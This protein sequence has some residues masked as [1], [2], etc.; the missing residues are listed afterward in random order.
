MEKYNKLVRDKIPEI[1][2]AK[3]IPYEKR[4]AS[5]GEYKDEL[6]K[7]LK[8]EM[9]EFGEAGDPSELADVLEVIEAL[10]MLPEYKNVEEVRMKKKEER[11]GFEERIIL[12]GEK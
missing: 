12:K 11:G 4:I 2:D 1:L 9:Q 5:P 6:V 3:K 10:K 8:E 7:K